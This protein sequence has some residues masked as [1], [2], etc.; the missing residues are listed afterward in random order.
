MRLEIVAPGQF[1]GDIISD[2]NS[3]RGHIDSIETQFAGT[4]IIR[5][6]VP[7]SE[8]FG[9]TTSLRSLTQGRAT[10]TM[11]FYQYREVPA[12]MAERIITVGK[13]NA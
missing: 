2:L 6:L 5:A 11:E 7:L 9:Y 4:C 3:R 12:E 13:R 1:M 8:T 10:H